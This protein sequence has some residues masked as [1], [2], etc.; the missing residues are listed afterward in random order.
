VAEAGSALASLGASSYQAALDTAT[1]SAASDWEAVILA[2][3]YSCANSQAT[4][5]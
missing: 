2:A 5:A 1:P 3:S 4:L